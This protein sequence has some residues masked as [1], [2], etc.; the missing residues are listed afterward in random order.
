[1]GIQWENILVV[2]HANGFDYWLIHRI[3]MTYFVWLLPEQGFY[4]SNNYTT[5]P[6]AVGSIDYVG[7]S[8][9]SVDNKK[10]VGFTYGGKEIIL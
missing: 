3:R 10:L 1:M 8:I 6:L 2:Q 9:I 7:E 4:F 5:P